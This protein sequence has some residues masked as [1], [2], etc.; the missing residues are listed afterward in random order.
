LGADV[1][2]ERSRATVTRDHPLARDFRRIEARLLAAVCA[3]DDDPHLVREGI[4]YLWAIAI[5]GTGPFSYQW[6]LNG[7]AISAVAGG[8]VNPY[9][10]NTVLASHAGQL[11]DADYRRHRSNLRR[12][13]GRA[14]RSALSRLT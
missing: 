6:L 13:A 5:T 12:G 4:I 11:H 2:F 14:L 7:V 10:I 3:I 8:T 9:V 1:I